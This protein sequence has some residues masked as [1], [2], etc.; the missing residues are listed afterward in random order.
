M[1]TLSHKAGFIHLLGRPN[2][3]K[4]TLFN[5]LIKR[6]LA[7]TTPK[8]QTTRQPLVGIYSGYDYQAVYMDTP[9]YIKPSYPLQQAMMHKVMR[10]MP[11]S[12]I[13]VWVVDVK[14]QVEEDFFPKTWG[15]ANFP[16]FLLINKRDLVEKEIG[17][18][19]QKAWEEVVPE[20]VAV[21]LISALCKADVKALAKKFIALLPH[22][23]PYYDKEM[24]TDRP[25]T[26]ILAEII[27]KAL[28][29]HYK[30]EVPYSA[31]VEISQ[32]VKV[33]EVMH[34]TATIY[35][36]RETQKRIVIGKKGSAL[37]QVGIMARKELEDF[38]KEKVF[39]KQYVKVVPKW[40][41]NF[42]LLEQWGYT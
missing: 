39:L 22:H 41:A 8:A 31:Q 38:L 29:L 40:R 26:Y 3:G 15:R 12:D 19:K 20:G 33:D 21:N 25:Q 30:Q 27:R 17:L 23:P 34:I 13:C 4:S 36:E 35:V 10:S 6:T 14:D 1:D 18:S 11:G 2:V 42:D 5:H 7:I 9:G 37:K 24:I 32:C 16:S 28:L